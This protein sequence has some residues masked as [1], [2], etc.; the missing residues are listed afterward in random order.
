MKLTLVDLVEN[1]KA[2]LRAA[3]QTKESD[4]MF[5]V[6]SATVTT[7]IAVVQDTGAKGG[8]KFYIL[9]AEVSASEKIQSEHQISL[10]LKTPAGAPGLFLGEDADSSAIETG[11]D[12]RK[13]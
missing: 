7:K 3:S 5:V 4:R 2:E 11:T 6:D 10:V 8:L 1:L 13:S 12:S 9:S